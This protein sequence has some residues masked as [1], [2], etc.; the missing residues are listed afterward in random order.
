MPLANQ[1]GELTTPH[2]KTYGQ[3]LKS[4][5]IIGGSSAV[6]IG[7][8]IV[9]TKVM[10]LLLGPAGFGLFGIYGAILDLVR[11]IGGMGINTSGVRQI[12]EAD[13]SGDA[14]RLARTVTTLRRVAFICGAFGALLLVIFSKPI[15]KFSFGNVEQAGSLVLL[16]LAVFFADVSA[17]QAAVVQGMRRLGDLARINIRG[18]LYGTILSIAIVLYFFQ[19][20]EPERGIVPSLVCIAAM[21][22]LMS[23][24]YARKIKVEPVTMTTGEV[25]AEVSGLLKLGF[26]FMTTALMSMAVAYVVRIIVWRQL[27]ESAAGYYSAA[28]QLG[29]IYVGFIL[30]A[31]GTDFYPRLTAV[32]KDN[33]ECNRLVNEQTEVGLLMAGPGV[34]GTLTFA[35]LVI[36]LFY[37]TKFGPAVEVLRWIC[38]GMVLRVASWPMGFILGAKG[39]RKAIFLSELASGLLQIGLAWVCVK[40]FGLNGTGIAF[41]ASYIAY[42]C[43]IYFIVRSVSGFRWT[44]ENKQIGL[45]YLSL[46]SV[47]FAGWYS[48][49]PRPVVVVGGVVITLFASYYSA[50]KLCALVPLDRLPK[51]VQWVAG[52]L[53]LSPAKREP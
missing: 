35:P 10:A 46:V 44:T 33:T 17:G 28:W 13:G 20:G 42:G 22:I 48:N 39:A 12:A 37:S 2:K 50:K 6:N 30:S 40:Q 51:P 26:V 43:M 21:G 32:V 49:L 5:A 7:L 41:F 36:Q 11:A 1:A 8:N 29:G 3:I 45:L 27:D 16:A 19:Q 47:V 23:W 34:L 9:R 14:M 25:T 52:V 15:S 24:W 31:M 4:S 38:L 18:A 53:K